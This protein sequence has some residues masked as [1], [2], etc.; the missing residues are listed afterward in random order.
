ML[1]NLLY[2]EE[3]DS[4]MHSV[5]ILGLTVYKKIV[6]DCVAKRTL[7]MGLIKHIKRDTS[8]QLYLCGIKIYHGHRKRNLP[9]PGGVNY[10][11]MTRYIHRAM[12]IVHTHRKTFAGYKN[13]HNGQT[14]TLIAT[15]P[16][17]NFY[18]PIKNS[19]YV[20][21]NRSCL[22]KKIKFDYMFVIDKAGL[23]LGTVNYYKEFFEYDCVKFVGD[24][25]LGADFQ[26]PESIA[27]KY[28]NVCRY[29]TSVRHSRNEIAFDLENE[30]LGNFS[31]VALQAIQF[32]MYTNPRRIY[33]VGVDCT[34]SSGQHFTGPTADIT[35]KEDLIKN[36]K[37][38]IQ[39]WQKVRIFAETYYPETEIISI[40]PI[41]LRGIFRDVYTKSFLAEH[42]EIDPNTVEILSE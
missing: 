41:G 42:P 19:I 4:N 13:K 15:G 39:S 8:V 23:D 1:K 27:L 34:V 5:R 20:G 3:R 29:K 35:R 18:K 26:I 37:A 17:S 7:L 9:P 24:Q 22:L 31:S 40:N 36:D 16:T 12:S 32:I 28:D 21:V 2:S 30:P 10:Y 38:N 11:E 25:N 33:I 14:I 6:S